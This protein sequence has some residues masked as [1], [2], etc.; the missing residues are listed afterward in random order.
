[1]ATVQT[2]RTVPMKIPTL[3]TGHFVGFSHAVA[4]ICLKH[5]VGYMIEVKQ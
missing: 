5:I 2:S 1:M 3:V 4:Q